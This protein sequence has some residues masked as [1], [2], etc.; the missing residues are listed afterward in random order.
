MYR[1]LEWVSR[2]TLLWSDGY[3]LEW[4]LWI[5]EKVPN[6]IEQRRD[7]TEGNFRVLCGYEREMCAH[8]TVSH[9]I[10]VLS[11]LQR[12]S[13]GPPCQRRCIE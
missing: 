1:L 3:K 6:K 11:L 12:Q 10:H 4:L 5:W 7:D 8:E 13:A 9:V 2:Q